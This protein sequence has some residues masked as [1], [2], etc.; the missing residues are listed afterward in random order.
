[1]RDA[2]KSHLV[3]EN[4]G[5]A[6]LQGRT[7]VH[8]D[9][10]AAERQRSVRALKSSEIRYR[11]LF[12][13]SPYGILVLDAETGVVTDAN[14][15]V[16]RLLGYALAEVL[17][18]PLWSIAAFKNAAATKN[19][20]R[21]LQHRDRVQYDDLPLE[22]KDGQIRHVELVSTLFLADGKPFVQC[23]V[24]DVTDRLKR[25]EEQGAR[26]EQADLTA[27]RSVLYARDQATHDDVTGMV[28]PSYLEESLPRELH[29]A[30]R[31][32]VPLTLTRLDL[33]RF[34]GLTDAFGRDAGDAMLREVGRVIREHLR[35][36]D[37]ACRS[38]SAEF[39][40]VLPESSSQATVDRVEQIR[41]ALKDLELHHGDK[42]LNGLTVSAGIATAGVHGTTTRELLRAA[43]T[44]VTAAHEGGG[45]RVV[46]HHSEEN[47]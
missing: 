31:A 4:P 45:D 25:E 44:A 27:A 22:T 7:A 28:N 8:L 35:K 13:T 38:G 32:N 39:V 16:C 3:T 6:K 20:F 9:G 12:E 1:M 11:R 36:S 15:V 14:P 30:Q 26:Q 41:T 47:R 24:R 23:S 43:Q 34:Q 17:D 2:L 10:Q 19:Q 42:L 33:D 29:R 5:P 18:H 46:L 37:M 21:E 40:L